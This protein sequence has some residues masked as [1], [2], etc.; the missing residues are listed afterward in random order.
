MER[1]WAANG[2]A[3]TKARKRAGISQENLAEQL[4]ISRRHMIRL[5][6]GEHLPS[7]ETR[8]RIVEALSADDV[9]IRSVDD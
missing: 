4:G 6:N 7:R 8:D 3:I 2:E 9:E 5:E 1:K